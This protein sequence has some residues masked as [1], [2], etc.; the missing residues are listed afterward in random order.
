[1]AQILQ[2]VRSNLLKLFYFKIV[3]R[4]LSRRLLGYFG[5]GKFLDNASISVNSNDLSLVGNHKEDPSKWVFTYQ[6]EGT[7]T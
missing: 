4:S 7:Y 1:M 6:H 2:G 3:L 5:Q